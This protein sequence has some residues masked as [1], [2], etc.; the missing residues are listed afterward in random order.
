MAIRHDAYMTLLCSDAIGFGTP[1]STGR[2]GDCF[3]ALLV[4]FLEASGCLWCEQEC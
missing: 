3:Y 1:V 2:K 4:D